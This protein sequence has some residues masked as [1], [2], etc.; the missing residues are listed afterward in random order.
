MIRSFEKK[1][2]V[3]ALQK[4]KES[5][6]AN[7]NLVKAF[8][9]LERE[10]KKLNA[11]NNKQLIRNNLKIEKWESALI[12]KFERSATKFAKQKAN[13]EA[14][15]LNKSIPKSN[16]EDLIIKKFE[17]SA[18]SNLK[19]LQ[20]QKVAL[21]TSPIKATKTHK[22]KASPAKDQKQAEKER[23]YKVKRELE[24]LQAKRDKERERIERE[25]RSVMPTRKIDESKLV[26]VRLDAKTVVFV[27]PGVDP[28]TV[29]NKFL[30]SQSARS[31]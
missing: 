14:R 12:L 20:K 13:A 9:Q 15:A 11:A 26:A 2:I 16:W 22:A 3:I 27:K 7:A 1:A 23:L 29:R 8:N 17:D 4:A 25:T 31:Q 21:K 24:K 6:K 19:R 10:H 28:E 5:A 18:K 30:S